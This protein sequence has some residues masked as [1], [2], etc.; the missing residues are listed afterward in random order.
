[1]QLEQDTGQNGQ[2]IQREEEESYRQTMVLEK[3]RIMDGLNGKRFE[4]DY[5]MI[6]EFMEYKEAE[7]KN[8]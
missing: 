3:G 2:T 6:K 1:M 5:G 7:L 4:R 8:L